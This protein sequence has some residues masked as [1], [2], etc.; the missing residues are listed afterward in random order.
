M[1]KAIGGETRA[2][3]DLEGVEHAAAR[4][5]KELEVGIPNNH[6]AKVE[7]LQAIEGLGNLLNPRSHVASPILRYQIEHRSPRLSFELQGIQVAEPPP[8]PIWSRRVAEGDRHV[9]AR[10]RV[11]LV[12]PPAD[13]RNC[14]PVLRVVDRERRGEEGGI[15]ASSPFREQRLSPRKSTGVDEQRQPIESRTDRESDQSES[16]EAWISR[17]R[18]AHDGGPGRSAGGTASEK[19][20][21]RRRLERRGK[22]GKKEGIGSDPN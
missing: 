4:A 21:R 13:Q 2:L 20:I 18:E 6:A 11:E 17:G 12:P 15:T 10:E 1:E 3:I 8:E 7:R 16:N 5:S 14:V 19:E 9:L 22:E